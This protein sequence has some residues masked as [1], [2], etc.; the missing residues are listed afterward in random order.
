MSLLA[1]ATGYWLRV[2]WATAAQSVSVA[3]AGAGMCRAT[4]AAG[5]GARSRSLATSET[6]TKAHLVFNRKWWIPITVPTTYFLPQKP[7]ICP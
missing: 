6:W 2:P 4:G 3:G 7:I 5:G 1:T